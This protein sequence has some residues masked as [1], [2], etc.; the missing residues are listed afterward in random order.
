MIY[1]RQMMEFKDTSQIEATWNDI[2]M[3]LQRIPFNRWREVLNFILFLAYQESKPHGDI[4][5]IQR[6]PQR[7]FGLCRGQF[8]VPADFDDPLPEEILRE[9]EG[10]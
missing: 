10:R 4:K 7:P 2:L 9:F 5:A 8:V 3:A 1:S 6:A